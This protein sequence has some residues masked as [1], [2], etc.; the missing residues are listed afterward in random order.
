MS[1]FF[2]YHEDRDR[3]RFIGDSEQLWE[4]ADKGYHI[5]SEQS[6]VYVKGINA[7]YAYNMRSWY[8]RIDMSQDE[9]TRLM[10]T[11]LFRI[12]DDITKIRT[13]DDMIELGGEIKLANTQAIDTGDYYHVILEDEGEV[14]DTIL[15]EHTNGKGEELR[16]GVIVSIYNTNERYASYEKFID[17]ITDA[18]N[19]FKSIKNKVRIKEIKTE[20]DEKMRAIDER[21]Q[22]EMYAKADTKIKDLL[23]E[24]DNMK[25]ED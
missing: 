17:V 4:N 23:A 2:G 7:R 10:N 24:L 1:K 19:A 6:I 20:I 15:S 11:T 21:Q 8:M 16:V 25:V 18:S 14:G 3:N 22:L 9:R 5:N 13:L 12:L